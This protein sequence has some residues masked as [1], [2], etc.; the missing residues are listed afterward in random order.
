MAPVWDFEWSIGIGWYYGDRPR[1]P[2]YWCVN[3][4]YFSELLKKEAFVSEVKRQWNLL[5]ATYPDLAGTIN[6]QMDA[7]AAEIQVS[8]QLNFLR[9]DI[10]EKQ[11]SV[12]GVPLGSYEA[13]LECDKRFMTSRIDWL[14]TV[15]PDL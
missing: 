7:Y 8:Q 13:E 2:G 14:A 4:W 5:R 3:G 11:V 12:G 1:D 15:I 9:W 10:L 6:A